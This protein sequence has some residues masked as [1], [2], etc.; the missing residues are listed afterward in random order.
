MP[1]IRRYLRITKYSVLECRIYPENPALTESWLL[2][3]RKNI[4]SRVI[5]SIHPLV[6]PKLREERERYLGKGSKKKRIKDVVV[7]DDFEVSVFLTETGTRHSLLTKKKCFR[8][9]RAQGMVSNST[10][11]LGTVEEAAIDLDA[12]IIGVEDSDNEEPRLYDLPPAEPTVVGDTSPNTT[13]QDQTRITSKRTR[14]SQSFD[15]ANYEQSPKRKKAHHNSFLDDETDE[16]KMIM[17]TTYDGF[18]VYGRALC[19]V[20]RRRETTGKEP[21][22][23]AAMENWIVSTQQLPADEET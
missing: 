2:N 20:V 10:K 5:E 18:S 16:K 3:P 7:Q 13:D 1:L 9:P 22:G 6:L 19:L 11:L 15:S 23:Q 12:T 14:D 4:L 8:N 17:Q 21:V